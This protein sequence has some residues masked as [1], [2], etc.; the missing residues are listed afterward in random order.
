VT[1]VV[2]AAHLHLALG[3]RSCA[4]VVHRVH[5]LDGLKS[6]DKVHLAWSLHCFDVA[7]SEQTVV[8]TAY[9]WPTP[10]LACNRLAVLGRRLVSLSL[11]RHGWF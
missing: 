8:T 5:S 1:K 6:F 2:L 4:R 9:Q 10:F 3:W 11:L 7:L